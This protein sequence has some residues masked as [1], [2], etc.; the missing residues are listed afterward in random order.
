MQKWKL[1]SEREVLKAVVFR[2]SQKKLKSPVREVTGDFDI[3]SC[4]NWVNVIALNQAGELLM[5]RQYRAGTDELT[6][7]LPAGALDPAEDPLL[8]AKRE[9]QEETGH[10]AINWKHLGDLAVNPAFMT[11]TCHVYIARDCAK[12]HDLNLDELEEIEV[13][14][15]PLKEALEL[16]RNGSAKHSLSVASLGLAYLQGELSS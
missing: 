12:T 4:A 2:Y 5:V 15:R 10:T 16:F 8:A 1:L 6:I 13:L 3:V 14:K 9:L 7:E 11:N